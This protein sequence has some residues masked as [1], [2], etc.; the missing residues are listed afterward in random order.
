M[1]R[2]LILANISKI[3]KEILNDSYII[4]VDKGAYV[5]SLNQI[6]M[7]TAIGDFDSIDSEMMPLIEKYS[8]RIIKLNSI[9]DF[10]DTNEA[11]GLCNPNDEI[12]ILG[13][14]QGKR[15]EHFYAN[16]IELK[17]NPNLKMIDDYSLIETK[18]NSFI[19]RMDYKYISFFSLE[20]ESIISLSGFSYNLNKYVLK[21][22]D[23]L[24]I[25]NEI[26]SKNPY[27]EIIKGRLL[28][29]YTKE[30]HKRSI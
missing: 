27:V 7:D 15:I 16:I 3:D 22:N 8:K 29:I 28:V 13:G 9:K 4:G 17:N 2:V 23:P 14:I 19:P 20:N 24:C 11:L 5:A 1:K 12:I 21:D 26:N 6:T 18:A 10:T 30:D 25:S